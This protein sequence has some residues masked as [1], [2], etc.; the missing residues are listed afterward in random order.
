MWISAIL[1]DFY[2]LDKITPQGKRLSKQLH[3]RRMDEMEL[4]LRQ[5]LLHA[6]LY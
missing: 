2:I 4:H 3:L 6:R 1:K 5:A